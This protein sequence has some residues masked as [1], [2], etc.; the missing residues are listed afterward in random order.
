[1]NALEAMGRGGVLS[2]SLRKDSDR[3]VRVEVSDTGP[4]IGKDE[5]SR[6][7]DPYFTTKSSGTGL[8]LAVV[9][10]VVEAHGGEL[11]VESVPGKGTT[12]SILLPAD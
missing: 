3:R 11:Q 12:V 2:V 9:H 8:G 4:G 6:I 10:K 5:V 7:F 1:L